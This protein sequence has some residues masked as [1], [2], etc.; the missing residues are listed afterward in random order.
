MGLQEK[1]I[2]LALMIIL[3]IPG[4]NYTQNDSLF[5]L[6]QVLKSYFFVEIEETKTN[7]ED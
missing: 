7:S 5:Y 6:M 1:L 4:K 3:M 2:W